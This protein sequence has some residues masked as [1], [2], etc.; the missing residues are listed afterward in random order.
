MTFKEEY[1]DDFLTVFHESCNLIRDFDGCERLRLLRDKNDTRIF[2]T[3]SWWD[4]EENL[5]K[6]RNSELFAVVWK[7]TKSLFDD[8]PEAWTVDSVW[9]NPE[10]ND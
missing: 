1:T 2:F 10:S 9:A 3:Y 5:E 7:K 6:Y 8:K 4:N